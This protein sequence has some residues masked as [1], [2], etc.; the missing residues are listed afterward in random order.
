MPSDQDLLNPVNTTNSPM[1]AAISSSSHANA[2][3]SHHV[4]ANPIVFIAESLSDQPLRGHARNQHI[5]TAGTLAGP[6]VV[7]FE[8]NQYRIGTCRERFIFHMW[9]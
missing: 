6:L 7:G 4:L 2:H 1:V 5:R 9:I 8:A 3:H